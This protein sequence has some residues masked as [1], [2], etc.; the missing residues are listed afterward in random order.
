M[1]VSFIFIYF[2]P[3]LL[4]QNLSFDPEWNEKNYI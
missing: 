1:F 4:F 2:A 3:Y